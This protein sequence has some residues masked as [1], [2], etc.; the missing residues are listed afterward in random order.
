MVTDLDANLVGCGDVQDD[1]GWWFNQLL[2]SNPVAT[3]DGDNLQLANADTAVRF[4]PHAEPAAWIL[5]PKYAVDPST[6]QLHVLVLEGACANGESP[7]GRIMPPDI[8]MSGSEIQVTVWIKT[9]GDAS[10]PG[11]SPYPWV[12]DLP[13]PVGNRSIPGHG[14]SPAFH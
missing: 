8:T 12:I 3:F 4:K 11:N 13:E 10:C 6:T 5:D 9:S 7:E 2:V 1:S 14:D